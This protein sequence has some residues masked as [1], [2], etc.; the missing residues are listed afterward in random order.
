MVLEANSQL[1]A[2]KDWGDYNKKLGVIIE[3]ER[4][5]NVVKSLNYPTEGEKEDGRIDS[6]RTESEAGG[7]RKSFFASEGESYVSD[8]EEPARGPVY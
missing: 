3:A 1:R 7:R 6:G 8:L 5:L 4:I 2:A